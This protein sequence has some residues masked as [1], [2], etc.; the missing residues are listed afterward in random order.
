MIST[1]SHSYRVDNGSA[2][3]D[4]DTIRRSA[5]GAIWMIHNTPPWWDIVLTIGVP[6]LIV[7][8]VFVLWV[9]GKNEKQRKR[10]KKKMEDVWAKTKPKGDEE[11]NSSMEG[12]SKSANGL[13][14]GSNLAKLPKAHAREV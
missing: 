1:D 8:L 6:I 13:P 2:P 4:Y 3:V 14:K 9:K 10:E 5:N 12:T 11:S 7:A